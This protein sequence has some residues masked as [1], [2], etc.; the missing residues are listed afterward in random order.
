M[1]TR[2][3]LGEILIESG[4][5]KTEDIVAALDHQ[6]Q[7]GGRIG[8]ILV[9]KGLLSEDRLIKELSKQLRLP[10]VDLDTQ[11]IHARVLSLVTS[12]IVA[13][14]HVI[15]VGMKREPTGDF[16]YVATSAPEDLEALRS[17]E[18]HTGKNVKVMLASE[19]AL[20]R[21]IMRF[22]QTTPQTREIKTVVGITPF[23]IASALPQQPLS[24][25]GPSPSR[26]PE[27][28][29][30]T[31]PNMQAVDV[32]SVF[33]SDDSD[34]DDDATLA[35][36]LHRPTPAS[37]PMP[38][39]IVPAVPPA[40][41]A[42]RS[43]L[44]SIPPAPPAQFTP[45]VPPIPPTQ[46]QS[47]L[48]PIAP[49]APATPAVVVPAASTQR[50]ASNTRILT[51]ERAEELERA[52]TIN[53]T[54]SV[55]THAALT[56]RAGNLLQQASRSE[57]QVPVGPLFILS[58][59][60]RV[61][62]PSSW[63]KGST[64]KPSEQQPSSDVFHGSH[65]VLPLR[66]NWLATEAATI[67][68]TANIKIEFAEQRA[69]LAGQKPKC[70]QCGEEKLPNAKFC[71]Y[72]GAR[73]AVAAADT[74]PPP[75]K[76]A[77]ASLAVNAALASPESSPHIKKSDDIFKV[78]VFEGTS[79]L[80]KLLTTEQAEL[81][82]RSPMINAVDATLSDAALTDDSGNLLGRRSLGV[83]RNPAR[84]PYATDAAAV[85]AVE[86]WTGRNTNIPAPQ[87]VGAV[88]ILRQGIHMG[89]ASR[90]DIPEDLLASIRA[91]Q[92][93]FVDPDK[94]D[95]HNTGA[96][97]AMVAPEL[98]PHIKKSEHLFAARGNAMRLLTVEQA[99][100]ME[101]APM[102]N[103]VDATLSNAA[104]TDDSGNLLGRRSLG[105]QRN[106]AIL[107]YA[108][109]AAAVDAVER[110]TGR[111]TNIPA[112]Q[113]VGAVPI[114]RQ[115]VQVG[116]ASHVDTI[117][118][119]LISVLGARQKFDAMVTQN[120]AKAAAGGVSLGVT[121]PELSPHIKKAQDV[122]KPTPVAAQQAAGATSAHTTAHAHLLTIEQA[123][124]IERSPVINN[125][126]AAFSS[127]ALT[128]DAG[129]LLGR[130]Q[131]GVQRT[132]A[133]LPYATDAAAVDAVERWTGRNT[134]IPAPQP[135]GAV[136]ILRQGVQVGDASLIDTPI[137]LLSSIHSAREKFY[138]DA[139]QQ[140]AKAEAAVAALSARERPA[141]KNMS[142]DAGALLTIDAVEAMERAPSAVN[143]NLTVSETSL[144][145][146]AEGI[147]DT[148]THKYLASLGVQR[149][150]QPVAI[151]TEAA[152]A[153]A[154][155]RWEGGNTAIPSAP[156]RTSTTPM[157]PEQRLQWLDDN[158]S[159][160][161]DPHL[162]PAA[163]HQTQRER[164]ARAS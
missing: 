3:K 24:Q 110:W 122:F 102:I 9:S 119:L 92:A 40:P 125:V 76:N 117:E 153:D 109:D 4:H 100:L 131:L 51:V 29:M 21:A 1:A 78:A 164:L 52:P 18:Q 48:S 69:K 49:T 67:D 63:K 59:A 60:A 84:L 10:V 79:H 148:M 95:A 99:E 108:T 25:M 159:A 140:Q 13:K 34:E 150:V 94:T 28:P 23:P 58:T 97:L 142:S 30:T 139:G 112:P 70:H 80:G 135:V 149:M 151:L 54:D 86:R 2:K 56:D 116:D 55:W 22:Y 130:H 71:P 74:T 127:A 35:G 89:D 146:H 161:D 77:A 137:A 103:A 72:C 20:R 128:D 46:P 12:A 147:I 141:L 68:D 105:V 162:M 87:P 88:P 6:R 111:N 134:N 61:D 44:P 17:V 85:D 101:R 90:V 160:V 118:A 121:A 126:D 132:A 123:E 81:M 32:S 65:A 33:G 91:A 163:F 53:W 154:V 143:I 96:L 15:P 107:P 120:Q 73:Y 157:H 113:P 133:Q 41:P 145:D 114:L 38:N 36:V 98:S 47:A 11:P 158:A 7:R 75:P 39:P 115:G 129:N 45:P 19:G 37:M 66:I 83:Q 104:L 136:P 8:S 155:W 62:E 26:L 42:I 124:I 152:S 93:A 64:I 156:P 106:P 14:Y 5:I 27:P 50:T 16:L 138:R 43:S 144:T 57:V 82:E 31:R